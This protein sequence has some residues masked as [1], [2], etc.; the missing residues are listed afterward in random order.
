MKA[1]TTLGRLVKSSKTCE[2]DVLNRLYR[3]APD[4]NWSVFEMLDAWEE[5][6]LF[7]PVETSRLVVYPQAGDPVEVILDGP[8]PPELAAYRA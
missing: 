1:T 8:L 2:V 6:N 5:P 4:V 3:I 7:G